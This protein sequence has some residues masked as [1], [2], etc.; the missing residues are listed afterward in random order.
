MVVGGV[1]GL[2]GHGPDVDLVYCGGGCSDGDGDGEVESEVGRR[3]RVRE[4][5]GRGATSRA[6][7]RPLVGVAGV[8]L[9]V[10]AGV[11]EL[12]VDAPREDRR[13]VEEGGCSAQRVVPAGVLIASLLNFA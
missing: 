6:W 9:P 13:H 2:E 3:A 1:S 11:A 7:L 10:G 8:G 4:R 12:D 5:F